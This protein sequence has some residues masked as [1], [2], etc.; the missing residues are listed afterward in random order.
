MENLTSLETKLAN[1]LTE[2]GIKFTNR[3]LTC[4]CNSDHELTNGVT[5]N[6]WLM[7]HKNVDLMVEKFIDLSNTNRYES[8]FNQL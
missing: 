8:D 1:V 3:Q 5:F 6:N 4:V 7:S 2:K